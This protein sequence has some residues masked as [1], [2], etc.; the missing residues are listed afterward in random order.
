ML[1]LLDADPQA[2][3]RQILLCCSRQFA[4]GDVQHWW[5]PPLGQ[6]VRTRISDD[7]LW[8]PYVVAEYIRH[9]SDDGILAE[10]TAYLQAEPLHQ[11]ENE[12][13]SIPQVSEEL[14]SV[15]EHC[16]RALKHASAA[17]SHGLPLIGGGDWNDGMNHVGSEGKG[18][19]VWLA[20]FIYDVLNKFSEICLYQ[21]DQPLADRLKQQ[22]AELLN[23]I[24]K[25][26]WDGEWYI[27]AFY[28]SGKPLG[29]KESD[30]CRIDSISQ[31]WA[32]LSGGAEQGRA[33]TALKS[34]NRY[35]VK[36]E[37][38]VI[39]LLTPPFNKTA[40]DPGYIK[41]YYPGI[42]ENGGQY[43]HAAI[44]L[45]MAHARAKDCINAYR[46]LSMINPIHTTTTYKGAV[47]YENEPY[48]ITADISLGEPYTGKGGW[49]WYTGSAGWMYQAILHTL[50]G[51]NKK[52][53]RLYIDPAVP[54]Q[55]KE[56]FIDYKHGAALYSIKVINGLDEGRY[57]SSLLLDG[58]FIEGN[59]FPLV[60]DGAVHH[61]L[62][63]LS[64]Q[65]VQ[66]GPHQ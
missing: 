60:D 18:E 66:T 9:T 4:E 54:S 2:V 51:I 50:L 62:V 31:S 49:S 47:K 39:L 58:L 64:G 41:G 6:G 35:L 16:L 11:G 37:D 15:Y 42:R 40:S 53:G 34:A 3:R 45:A 12:V 44:W 46:L 22:A 23:N 21:H 30:E 61:A 19:S 32:V 63:C 5:H 8:L 7:L 26:A 56:Y 29:S 52:D 48:V 43:T 57:V 27:R 55:F 28:D 14:G 36:D 59:S 65:P 10:K 20:W 25:E 1:A 33:A 17:G 38:G 24:E 13:L